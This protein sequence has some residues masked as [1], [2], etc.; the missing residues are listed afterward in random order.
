[1]DGF[2]TKLDNDSP[3][4]HGRFV[5]SAVPWV[6]AYRPDVAQ[7]NNKAVQY[8]GKKS[9]PIPTEPALAKMGRVLPNDDDDNYSHNPL[10]QKL[11][12]QSIVKM[13]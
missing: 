1:L 10:I 11:Q 3:T 9:I 8:F 12:Q 2:L 6:L 7:N 4:L 13:M 5:P